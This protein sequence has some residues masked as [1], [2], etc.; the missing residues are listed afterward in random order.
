M[1]F[2][3]WGGCYDSLLKGLLRTKGF[4]L[5]DLNDAQNKSILQQAQFGMV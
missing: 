2:G 3:K 1:L 4:V 5:I